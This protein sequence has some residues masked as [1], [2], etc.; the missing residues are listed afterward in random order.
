M[1]HYRLDRAKVRRRLLRL[2]EAG[3]LSG[4]GDGHL[5]GCS[6]VISAACDERGRYTVRLLEDTT[7]YQRGHELRIKRENVVPT[8]SE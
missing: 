6:V 8:P 1:K 2:D 7:S 4:L 3:T 5:N